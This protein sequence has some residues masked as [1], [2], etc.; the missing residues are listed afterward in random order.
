MDSVERVRVEIEKRIQSLLDQMQAD[1][2]LP[3]DMNLHFDLDEIV[4]GEV[5]MLKLTR[6]KLSLIA[7]PNKGV[8]S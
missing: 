1:G 2:L 3:K 6:S 7:N 4:A 5:D 8:L